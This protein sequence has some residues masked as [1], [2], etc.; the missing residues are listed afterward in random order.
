MITI[1]SPEEI[2][3]LKMG[4]K[5]LA[6][7]LAKLE[8]EA[9]PGISTGYLNDLAEKWIK[10]NNCEPS[11]KNYRVSNLDK[12]YPTALCAS[13][14]EVI[15]HQVPDYGIILKEGDILK[16]DLGLWYP[17][18]PKKLCVD[19][20]ITVAIGKVPKEIKKMIEIT[21]KSL[22]LAIK[23]IKPSNHSGD[24]GFAIQKCAESEGFG[25]IRELVGH[26]VG[27]GVHEDPE[28]F[29]YGS[30]GEGYALKSGM[31]LAIEPMVSMG[32]WRIVKYKDGFG[33]KTADNSLSTHFEHTVAVTD[34]GC[35]VLTLLV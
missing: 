34:K 29:N 4:G 35:E 24:I 27:Y 13:L 11:F 31:V 10:E 12:I 19:A 15:V 2:K 5:I 6:E 21:E 33:Y 7:I 25:V 3:Q 9:K 1:K 18:K 32:G 14:N 20:A 28:V 8:K 22:R 17:A 16:L 26:G 23:E 30:K